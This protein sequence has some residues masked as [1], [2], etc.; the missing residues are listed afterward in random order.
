[1]VIPFRLIKIHDLVAVLGKAQLLKRIIFV[2]GQV[3]MRVPYI[4]SAKSPAYKYKPSS[5]DDGPTPPWI[6]APHP[7]I[8]FFGTDDRAHEMHA[9]I[10]CISH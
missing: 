9:S 2:P 8:F 3:L 1:M 5:I 4:T 6:Q 7:W 10:R